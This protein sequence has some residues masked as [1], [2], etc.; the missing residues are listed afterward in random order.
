MTNGKLRQHLM[1]TVMV[2]PML[3]ASVTYLLAQTNTNDEQSAISCRLL[4]VEAEERLNRLADD[5][6][7]KEARKREQVLK[8]PMLLLMADGAIVDLSGEEARSQPTESWLV[9]RDSQNKATDTFNQARTAF[10][11]GD[12]AEC[13]RILRTYNWTQ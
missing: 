5:V 8:E 3:A 4:L 7:T 11:A 10:E 1:A 13:N 9:S 6:Q 2:L 12:E